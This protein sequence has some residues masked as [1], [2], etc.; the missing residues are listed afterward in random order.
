[1]VIE[2]DSLQALASLKSRYAGNVDVIYIDPPYNLGKD[3]FR[4]SDKRFHDP[5]ADDSDAVYVN[6]EDG[7]RHTKWLNFM[8]PRLYM[9]W[10]IL[11]ESRGV[12][13]VSINDVELFRLGL[14]MNEIFGEE[15][16]VGTI[17]WRGSTDNNPTRIAIEH[18]YI[19]CYAKVAGNLSKVWS[20]SEDQGRNFLLSHYKELR[21]K[22]PSLANL[23]KLWRKLIKD[24]AL[25][26]PR[27]GRYTE[28]DE[29]GPYQAAYRVHNPG[30]EGY[31][32][33]V[34]HPVTKKPCK[35]PLMGYRF[36][37]ETMKQLIAEDRIIFGKDENTIVTMKDYLEDFKD[38]LR[39]IIELDARVGAYTLANLFDGDRSI[40][41]N[42]KPV[43]LIE[44]LLSFTTSSN[45][46][47]LDA[48]AGSGTAGHAVLSLNQKDHGQRRF[49]LIEEGRGK[50]GKERFSRTLTAERIKR[51]IKRNKYADGFTFYETGRKLDRRAIVGLERDALANLI[52]QA[53]ETGRGKSITRLNGFKYVIGKNPRNEAICLLWKGEDK[54]EVTSDDLRAA[55]KE[56]SA[57]G[58]KRPFRIYGT[59]CRVSDTGTSWKFCQIPDEILAQMHIQE[60]L[61]DEE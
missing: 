61:E 38:T 43:E 19:L 30:K 35:Q 16:H 33:D 55:A 3:D 9:L 20:S 44:R 51:A 17:V 26:F 10:E 56:V 34:I 41:K 23:K 15:N 36:P 58:L 39:S 11:N 6:N 52:C 18:E 14:L 32:Y 4:Y 42:P 37:Q 8:A 22:T 12:I 46:I 1:M 57:A 45:S 54:S 48:F 47:V 40:F 2:G 31:R 5:D 60:D 7:G 50:N 27:L 29:H 21:A 25:A 24:N 28:V 53:D 59:F 49:I 13:F